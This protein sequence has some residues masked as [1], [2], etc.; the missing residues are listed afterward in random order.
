V[1]D[2]IKKYNEKHKQTPDGLAALGY[3]AARILFEAMKR[4]KSLGG[5]DLAAEL[6]RTKDFDGVTGRI[7]ID[8]DRNAVKPA[9]MLEMK[10]GQPEIVT[11]INPGR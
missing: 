2:F 10:D 5:A 1:Q 9:V 4:S 7:S 6:A 8:A 3:D 11:T